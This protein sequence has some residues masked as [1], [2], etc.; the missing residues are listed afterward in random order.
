MK[1]TNREYDIAIIEIKDSDN[2]NNYLDLDD[3]IIDDILKEDNN[4]NNIYKE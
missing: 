2:I 1:Y 3:Y 4:I